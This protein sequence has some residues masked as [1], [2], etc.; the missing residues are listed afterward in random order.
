MILTTQEGDDYGTVKTLPGTSDN[1]GN[2]DLSGKLV[3]PSV[4]NSD[5]SVYYV[6]EIGD[7]G[8]AGSGVTSVELPETLTTIGTSGL[9]GLT[10]IE[11]IKIPHN[12][13]SLGS[14][15]FKGCSNL[16]EI[17][18]ANDIQITEIP[19]S[20]FE[21]TAIT[22][23]NVPESVTSIGD[24]AFFNCNDLR[25]VT[26]PA[27]LTSLGEKA[28][29]ETPNLKTVIYLTDEPVSASENAF[30]DYSTPTLYAL[31]S[32]KDKYED[33]EPWN[34][35]TNTTWC[36]VHLNPTEIDL[37]ISRSAQLSATVVVAPGEMPQDIVWSSSDPNI[38]EV[39]N[40]GKVKA[41]DYG[42]ATVSSVAGPYGNECEVTVHDFTTGIDEILGDETKQVDIFN[43]Q[44]VCL[45]RNA[46]ADDI[47]TLAPGLY[48][49]GDKK[50]LIRE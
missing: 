23:I 19:Q 40:E 47:R 46:S 8:L 37:I 26:L 35:F 28:F 9:G 21:G 20:A 31:L 1:Y 4:V 34:K 2:S 45:K 49:I 24:N 43:L 14:S 5:G 41:I 10:G 3:I 44:G 30:S 50:V 39:D 25:T 18:F 16:K 15:V 6:T 38:V 27:G 29:G 32:E 17:T 11:D 22:S 33:I 42:H 12:V 13:E 7:Y 48:I 36:G